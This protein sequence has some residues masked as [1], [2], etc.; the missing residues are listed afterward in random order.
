MVTLR[1]CGSRYCQLTSG[2]P[3]PYPTTYPRTSASP[4]G[5]RQLTTTELEKAVVVTSIGCPGSAVSATV[6]Q[7]PHRSW[8]R[9]GVRR[10][11]EVNA[12]LARLVLGWVTASSGGCTISACNQPTSSTQPCI[13]SGSLNRVPIT[14][15]R[16]KR[17]LLKILLP[18]GIGTMKCTLCMHYATCSVG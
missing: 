11:N 6:N 7:S 1:R 12:R 8:R 16:R 9:G 18:N 17:T 15:K 4:L 2:T 3:S 14:K 10:M 5:G 13:P